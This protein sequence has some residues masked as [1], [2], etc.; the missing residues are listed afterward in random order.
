MELVFA[1]RGFNNSSG[2]DVYKFE[3]VKANSDGS[4]SDLV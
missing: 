4:K 1:R 2:A 3:L